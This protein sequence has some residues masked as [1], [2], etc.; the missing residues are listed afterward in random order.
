[1][2][3]STPPSPEPARG[4]LSQKRWLMALPIIAGVGL[5]MIAVLLVIVL[6]L[7]RLLP[8]EEGDPGVS[9]IVTK[10]AATPATPGAPTPP[11]TPKAAPSC[12]TIISSD[13]VSIVSSPP[14]SL[15][16]GG[17]SFPVETVLAE[18]GWG[19]PADSSGSAAWVC[20]TVVN[21]V[22]ALEP[23]TENETLLASLVS[24]DEIALRLSNGVVLFFSFEQQG[25]KG[26]D[27]MGSVF[28]QF[29]PSLT[30]L[31]EQD[32]GSWLVVSAAYTTRNAPVQ[33]SPSETLANLNVP[34][35]VGDA[36]VTVTDGH[37]LGSAPDLPAGTMYYLVEFSVENVGT[38][39]LN[40]DLFTMQ[41][42]DGLGNQ[43]LLSSVASAFGDSGLLEGALAPG[44]VASGSA[45]YRVPEALA[46]PTLVWTFSP[47]PG[48]EVWASVGIPYAG[49]PEPVEPARA[50]V[51]ITDALIGRDESILLI[52]GEIRNV[53]GSTLTVDRRDIT[54]TSSAGMGELLA[55]APKLPWTI[56]PGETRVIE[57]QFERPNAASVL[58]NVLGY[59]FEISGLE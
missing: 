16:L 7:S 51:T 57:L 50:E 38:T 12:E 29:E 52:E 55:D 44:E 28:E 36:Q 27:T 20:G 47:A 9:L 10:I 45:G 37:A 46:G 34:V 24:G 56:K 18:E 32:G 4:S 15:T 2:S 58:L 13:D 42:H 49:E 26:I 23:T 30:V 39:P 11:P 59:S 54:L 14:M 25:E 6:G 53:G 31:L 22:I 17:E 48:S 5:L 8:S 40:A 43:Y 41:L 3:R 19:Y 1:M 21:Y 35:R 33:P